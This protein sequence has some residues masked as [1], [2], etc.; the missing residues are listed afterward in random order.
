VALFLTAGNRAEKLQAMS[1]KID[2]AMAILMFVFVG[3]LVVELL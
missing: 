1:R 2:A 3:V